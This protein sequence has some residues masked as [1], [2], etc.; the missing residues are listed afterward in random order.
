MSKFFGTCMLLCHTVFYM[1]LAFSPGVT[2][3]SVDVRTGRLRDAWGYSGGGFVEGLYDAGTD[4]AKA[5][6]KRS[7]MAELRRKYDERHR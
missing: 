2:C 6:K 1:W 5:E 4:P 3:Q 7:D